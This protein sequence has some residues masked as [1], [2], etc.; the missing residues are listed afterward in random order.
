MGT[1]PAQADPNSQWPGFCPNKGAA[2]LF[3]VLFGLALLAHII[4]AIVYR[5]GYSWVIAMGALWQLACYV[6]RILSIEHVT[7]ELF[8]SAWFILMLVRSPFPHV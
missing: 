5:K 7:N 3:A 1:C 2:Y 8:Y 4:Q 6:F